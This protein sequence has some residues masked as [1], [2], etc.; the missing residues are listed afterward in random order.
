MAK[1][2]YL[3]QTDKKV[4]GV[5]GGIGE[6]FDVDSTIIRLAWLFAVFFFGAGLFAYIIAAI[7]VPKKQD[8]TV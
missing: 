2:L 4:C 3:S 7:I 8:L 5:C 1:K 6:Y